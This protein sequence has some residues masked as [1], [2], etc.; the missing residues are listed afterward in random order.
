LIEKY[1]AG[2]RITLSSIVLIGSSVVAV[3]QDPPAATQA[4]EKSNAA[5]P[6]DR[7][8][9]RALFD[10]KSLTNWQSTQFG[11]E[12][13]VAVKNEGVMTLGFGAPLTGVH[14]AGKEPLPRMNYE[15]QLEA[16][17][18]DGNDFFCGLTFPYH[19]SHCSLI[20]GGW[21][22]GLIGLS[23]LDGRDASENET[24]RFYEFQRGHWYV[25]R[26]K[27]RDDHIEAWLD[28]RKV[29]DCDVGGRSVNTRVE[30]NLSRPLGIASYETSAEIRAVRIR[31]LEK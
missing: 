2:L 14:W 23:S 15:L 20:L 16:R 6:V 18:V 31:E 22:G 27:V 28:D 12:G 8:T 7:S 1:S 29:V 19:D 21:G 5:Q 26:L 4:T 9:W 24:T 17:R 11:G 3:G 25:I 10:G 13:R 30:V